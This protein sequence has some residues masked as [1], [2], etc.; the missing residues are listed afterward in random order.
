MEKV[1]KRTKDNLKHILAR[2]MKMFDWV[3]E[4]EKRVNK[5][6]TELTFTR[7]DEVPYIEELRKLEKEYFKSQLIPNWIPSV[8]AGL[9]FVFL[10][11]FLVFGLLDPKT[12][13]FNL[14]LF[15]F[16][17]PAVVF[18]VALGILCIYNTKKAINIAEDEKKRDTMFIEKVKE[19]KNGN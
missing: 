11:L 14:S 10:T 18:G 1:T 5:L 13:G 8:V 19:L 9:A 16:L 4:G 3:V 7:D 2:Q 17:I 6:D 15:I 12:I